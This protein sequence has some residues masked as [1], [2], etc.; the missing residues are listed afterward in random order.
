MNEYVLCEKTDLQAI[1]ESL[2]ETSTIVGMSALKSL[3]KNSA[4]DG[5]LK[6]LAA[7]M[8]ATHCLYGE[9]MLEEKSSTLPITFPTEDVTVRFYMIWTDDVPG[10][11]S[12]ARAPT[13]SGGDDVTYLVC[14]FDG[15]E[16][17]V[18]GGAASS[19][20]GT[21]FLMGAAMSPSNM[22]ETVY[23][24]SCRAPGITWQGSN[25]CSSVSIFYD[26]DN[27]FVRSFDSSNQ[28]YPFAADTVYKYLIFYF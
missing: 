24:L 1:K 25:P 6:E 19:D 13:P 18:V 20:E 22:D 5:G 16:D 26:A 9:T 4:S 11:S 15:G 7:F 27:P 3:A 21:R 12:S 17:V 2:G 14:G 23:H 10:T 28:D 8:G